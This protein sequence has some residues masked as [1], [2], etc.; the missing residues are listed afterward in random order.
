MAPATAAYRAGQLARNQGWL[1]ESNPH[2]P[3][4]TLRHAWDDGWCW[5]NFQ[6]WRHEHPQSD[7]ADMAVEQGRGE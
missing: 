4:S 5:A 2:Q 3:R 1:R 6:A 7:W